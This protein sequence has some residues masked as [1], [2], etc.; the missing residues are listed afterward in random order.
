MDGFWVMSHPPLPE[1]R[2]RVMAE[3]MFRF[4]GEVGG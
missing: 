1:V 4:V 2:V 3:V